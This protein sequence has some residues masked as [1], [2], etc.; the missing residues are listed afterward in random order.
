MIITSNLWNHANLRG[1]PDAELIEMMLSPHASPS[2]MRLLEDMFTR[3]LMPPT[4]AE[5]IE[6]GCTIEVACVFREVEEEV[7]S[8]AASLLGVDQ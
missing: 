8:Y 1:L 4:Y 6:D 3:Y 5:E 7:S 2:F